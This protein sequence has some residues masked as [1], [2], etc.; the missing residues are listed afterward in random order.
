MCTLEWIPYVLRAGF[1]GVQPGQPPQSL[2][3]T[4]I[5]STDF[6]EPFAS[7]KSW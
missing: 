5:E 4:E 6:I 1:K 3:K 2:N 7:Q